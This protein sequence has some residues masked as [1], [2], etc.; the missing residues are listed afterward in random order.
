MNKLLFATSAMLASF[1]VSAAVTWEP[2]LVV[3]RGETF[4]MGT[5]YANATNW[6]VTVNGTLVTEL[7]AK[8][9]KTKWFV[10]KLDADGKQITDATKRARVEIGPDAGDD[11]V[12][13]L[14]LT[15]LYGW[16]SEGQFPFDVTIG[17]NGGKGKVLMNAGPNQ[18]KYADI[19]TGCFSLAAGA[20]TDEDV[21]D[22]LTIGMNCFLEFQTFRND[23]AKP[24][25]ITFQNREAN[26]NYGALS[27]Y[28]S[29]PVF[30][31]TSAGGDIILRG[32]A[33]APIY[34]K[35]WFDYGGPVLFST[36]A[37]DLKACVRMTG[38]CNVMIDCGGLNMASKLNATNVIWEQTGDL[39]VRQRLESHHGTAFIVSAENALPCGP[40]TGNVIIR[41]FKAG[42][43]NAQTMDLQASQQVNG[44]ILEQ[45]AYVG[46]TTA[47]RKSVVFGGRNGSGVAS[48]DFSV[49]ADKIE[50]SKAGSGT[51][52]LS[53]AT[54]EALAVTGGVLRIVGNTVNAIGTLAVTNAEIV[55]EANSN[56]L[57]VGTW[58]V[59][60]N[61]SKRAEFAQGLTSNV[62]A[63]V[64][65]VLAPDVPLVKDDDRFFFCATPADAKGAPLQVKRGYLKMGG[66]V[67]HNPYWRMTFKKAMKPQYRY[68]KAEFP[69]FDETVNL[70]VGHIGLFAANGSYSVGAMSSAAV[71]EEP[72]ALAE[73]AA[74][75]GRKLF[76]WG[77]ANW[78]AVTNQYPQVTTKYSDPIFGGGTGQTNPA[79]DVSETDALYPQV[80]WYDVKA[81][82]KTTK[83]NSWGS[84]L[85]F[86]NGALDPADDSTWET[87]SW[88]QK[89]AWAEKGTASYAL[90]RAVNND[91]KDRPHP[92][93]WL[94]ESSADGLI[95][96]TMDER[97]GQGFSTNS[98]GLK[99]SSQFCYTY[100]DHLPYLFSSKRSNWRFETFGAV[101]VAAGATLDLTELPPENIAV[102]ALRVDLDAGAGT[103]RRFVPAA[104]GRL[105]IVGTAVPTHRF[106]LPLA[107]TDVAE[108]DNLA[109]WS[110]YV[111]GVKFVNGRVSLKDGR[112]SVVDLKGLTII[113]R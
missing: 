30:R 92:T 32:D 46:S 5:A 16:A 97:S 49:N 51:L 101:E 29:N 77:A 6:S 37:N 80:G 61:V 19:R 17:R 82:D 56:P 91:W 11:A 45:C 107:V 50:Y 81:N 70:M 69:S 108:V 100:N 18:W 35:D 68:T 52:V 64:G 74:T 76:G 7:A 96:E 88:R 43:T 90:Q 31:M 15:Y 110:V 40:Q 71:G 23:N 72:S 99:I 38:D 13:D 58:L 24:M 54:F 27:P 94:L 79:V 87:I 59:G 36:S 42:A 104:N 105:D 65:A 34:I 73:G 75:V 25:R 85:A 41:P 22:V 67:C 109:S 12:L 112:L 63:S 47:G 33:A 39:I 113:I 4:T 86:A 78:K 9:A 3:P 44:I 21:F 14:R 66:E 55:Y 84:C 2:D 48:G 102:A 57:Q 106:D 10:M 111:N 62:V 95:W 60:E 103:I 28:G 20:R 98:E 53:N 83:I 26:P 89:A 8:D 93:D 1:V